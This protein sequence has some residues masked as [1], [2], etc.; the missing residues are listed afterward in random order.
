MKNF[1][2]I[3]LSISTVLTPIILLSPLTISFAI[4]NTNNNNNN[5]NIIGVD[6]INKK[7]IIKNTKTDIVCFISLNECITKYHLKLNIKTNTSKKTK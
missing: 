1:K 3:F 7:C 6:L 5:I 2:S 4:N